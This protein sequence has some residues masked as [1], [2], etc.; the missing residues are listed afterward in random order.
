MVSKGIFITAHALTH[1]S[2]PNH[3]F[4]I[5]LERGLLCFGAQPVPV[6]FFF[7]QRL[8]FF[9]VFRGQAARRSRGDANKGGKNDLLT[10]LGWTFIPNVG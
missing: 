6:V 7:L 2:S 4:G 5:W 9:S 10:S 3:P 1:P 8:G